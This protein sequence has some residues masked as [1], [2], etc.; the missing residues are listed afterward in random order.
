[1]GTA[2]II[3][4]VSGGTIALISGIYDHFIIA[5]SSPKISHI[6]DLFVFL[7][8]VLRG[9]PDLI[10]ASR[11]SQVT[12]G[13]GWKEVTG[14]LAEIHWSFLIPLLLGIFLGLVAMSQII[15]FVMH[16]YPFLT[17]SFFFGLILFSLTIPYGMMRKAPLEFFVLALFSLCMFLLVGYSQLFDGS[18]HPLFLFGSGA[19]AICA[20]VLPGI[21]GAFILVVLGEYALVL[22]AFRN[23][24]H[25]HEL[26]HNLRTMSFFAAG[27]LVG[28]FSFVRL[29]KYLLRH[30]HSVTMAALTGFMIGSLRKIW[31]FSYTPDGF[32]LSTTALWGLLAALIGAALVFALERISVAIGDP[33]PPIHDVEP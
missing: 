11:R 16:T 22:N 1:M 13:E 6:R 9:L 19:V 14:R 8:L 10:S 28:I 23:V 25:L 21:S 12:G 32:T 18:L 7:W 30:H 26:A 4:G 20:M 29:L 33:E 27:V 5:L 15:P 31:P 24:L 2:D 3:P 17:F